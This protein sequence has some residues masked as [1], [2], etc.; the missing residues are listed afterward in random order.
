MKNYVSGGSKKRREVRSEFRKAVDEGVRMVRA[1]E[2]DVVEA[3]NRLEI[4]FGL[5]SAER[6]TLRRSLRNRMVAGGGALEDMGSGYLYLSRIPF[7]RFSD[8][9]NG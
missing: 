9:S 6:G 7:E 5:N 1:G 2:C 4:T 3:V 8:A